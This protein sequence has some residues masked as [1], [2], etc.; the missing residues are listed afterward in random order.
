MCVRV[1]AR[2]SRW[3]QST[4]NY[5]I[6]Y[7][8]VY[9]VNEFLLVDSKQLFHFKWILQ[10]DVVWFG[11]T[12]ARMAVYHIF[13][14]TPLGFGPL[15]SNSELNIKGWYCSQQDGGDLVSLYFHSETRKTKETAKDGENMAKEVKKAE[16]NKK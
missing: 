8:S 2:S 14:L 7:L 3:K 12:R 16:R 9:E 1:A 5:Q 10:E 4:S 11:C 15:G 6:C 13:H